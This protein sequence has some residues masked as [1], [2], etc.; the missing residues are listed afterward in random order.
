[1]KQIHP[2]YT[3]YILHGIYNRQKHMYVYFIEL[4]KDTHSSA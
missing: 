4:T 3:L 1:M 2:L